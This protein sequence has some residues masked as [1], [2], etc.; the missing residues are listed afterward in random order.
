MLYKHG[1]CKIQLGLSFVDRILVFI[2]SKLRQNSITFASQLPFPSKLFH[3]Q[4]SVINF[5]D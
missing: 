5:P 2:Y 1:I 3:S 4:L